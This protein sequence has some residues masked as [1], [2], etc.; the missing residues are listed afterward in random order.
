MANG[1]MTNTA[2]LENVKNILEE[3]GPLTGK[4]VMVPLTTKAFFPGRLKPTLRK[5]HEQVLVRMAGTNLVE[6]DRSQAV[7]YLESRIHS[8]SQTTT[9][10]GT[11]AELPFFEIREELDDDG[12]EVTSEAVNV[13]KELEYLQK[14]EGKSPVLVVPVAGDDV[15]D[16]P[17]VHEPL[18]PVSKD[19]YET[20]SARLEELARLEEQAD[21]AK[22][23]NIKSSTKLQSK[24][25]GKGFLN[26]KPK[27]KRPAHTNAT[28][29]C[30]QAKKVGFHAHH[31][32]KE[33]PSRIG[34]RASASELITPV[35]A[36]RKEIDDK[37]FSGVIR[38]RPVVPG[39]TTAT[40]SVKP[41]APKKKLSRFAQERLE[42]K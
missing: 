11:N 20:I 42:Q 21:S 3:D 35:V 41:A 8:I 7:D 14:K 38:E 16:L 2:A 4:Q 18:R 28:T 10:K 40:E 22:A 27:A 34:Q 19:E 5:E 31:D 17:E 13:A 29:G 32:V 12:R 39:T 9:S 23:E 26:A 25:W 30:A 15:S 24:G 37:V 1:N 33:I 6:L 36:A